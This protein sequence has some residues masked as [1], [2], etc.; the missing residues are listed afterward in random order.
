MKITFFGGA[1]SVT[2]SHYLL[3][4]G[5]TK[6][7]ID[8][9]LAQGAKYLERENFEP[10]PY[11]P[12]EISAVCV[13]HAHIDHTGKLPRLVREGFRGEILS[14]FPTKDFA[15]ILL[16]D[17]EHVLREEAN[18]EGAP[19]LYA[20][21][22]VMETVA[23]WRGVEYRRP[24]TV[25]DFEIEFFD[26]GHVLGS[27]FIK[28][29]G[30]EKKTIVFSGDLGNY[31]EPMVKD[32]ETIP[33][34]DYALIESTY[35]NRV[36]EDAE[37]RKALLED[38]VEDTVKA[39]GTLMIPAFAMERTQ[40]LLYEMN[41]LVEHDR[42]PKI[43]VFVDS[44]LA[45]KLTS[46]YEKYARDPKYFDSEALTTEKSGDA[47]FNF[48][49]L[50][51][52]LTTAQ[53]KEIN[54]VQPPKV[55]IAGSGMSN[56]GR[57]LHHERRYLP[58]EKS[59][60]LFIGYQARGSLGRLILEGAKLVNMFGEEVPVRCRTCAISGY[61]AHADQPKLIEWLRPARA[62]L[63]KVFVVQGEE[64]QMIPLAQ[65]IR[66]ELAVRTE[67]PD[68]NESIDL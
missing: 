8:C 59:A 42:I 34:A 7:L 23:R 14:T 68:K 20:K 58:D 53:S 5:R 16:L 3:D 35:G 65:K 26:A 62:R 1:K 66:D 36:H 38:V 44:P 67:I 9:G 33:E 10:F 60:I 18:R 56:G 31:A 43:P 41:D 17:S 13:T 63:K 37:K 21:D 52:T 6:L 2:G 11:D 15:E 19:S 27:S 49:G 64:E 32:T 22:D 51:F 61:S 12:K 4:G 39:G 30:P 40:E 50:R 48:P 29:T 55:V 25:G 57:I 24:M 47:I 45:I 54:D 28:I 46:I